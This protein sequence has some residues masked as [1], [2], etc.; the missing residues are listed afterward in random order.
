MTQPNVYWTLETPLANF[1]GLY[2]NDTKQGTI[3]EPQTSW[4]ISELE[5]AG[6]E[7]AASGKAIIV[8]LHYPAYSVDNAHGS[9]E[10]MQ[11]FLDQ[12]FAQAKVYPDI[13]LTGHVHNYQ[14]FTRDLP[15]GIQLPYIVAGAG[16]YWNLHQVE[17]KAKPVKVPNST[18]FPDVTLESYSDD[19]HGFLRITID[20]TGGTRTLKGEYFTVPRLQESWSAPAV[21][22]DSFTIDLNSHQV[23]TN[24]V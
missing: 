6:A 23:T 8:G 16:G 19:R 22:F 1:V 7:R 2:C 17:T 20:T 12:A 9:S 5:N 11:T 10:E 15:N 14:R 18:F 24:Q 13:V 21:L 3:K 4:F